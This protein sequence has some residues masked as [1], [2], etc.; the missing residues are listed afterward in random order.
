M[1]Y[2]LLLI[3]IACAMGNNLLKNAF[4]KGDVCTEGDNAVYNAIACFIGAPLSLIGHGLAPMSGPALLWSALFGASMAGVAI[5][6][7]RAFR[8][9]PMA[10]TALFGDFSM[11]LPILFAFLFWREPISGL[12]IPGILLMF[13]AIY[14]MV[15]PGKG[16]GEK[17]SPSWV[18]WA[19]IFSLTTGLMS[20][21]QQISVKTVP[22]ESSMFLVAGFL[23]AT[24]FVL[25]YAA[26]CQRKEET[27]VSFP[28]FSRQ[29]LNGLIVGIFGGI[30]HI[31][32]VAILKLMDSAIFY[33]LKAG[34]CILFNGLLGWFLLKE[35]VSRRRLLGFILG[36][37]SVLLLTVV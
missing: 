33:P 18:L 22:E 26:F 24:L 1:Q 15:N 3:I 35:R 14:L 19:G 32:A 16:S 21:F 23:F 7:I 2:L 37:V 36:G 6:A 11:I 13:A 28:L 12:R 10:L 5:S 4:A 31:C 34:L 30:S 9:G 27:R 20:L 29:N 8:S 25:I 17:I